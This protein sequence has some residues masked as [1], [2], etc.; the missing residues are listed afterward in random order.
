MVKKG[1][2]MCCSRRNSS[3]LN[4]YIKPYYILHVV[5]VSNYIPQL[6]GTG[7]LQQ[8]WDYIKDRVTFSSPS[9]PSAK[10][11]SQPQTL[12]GVLKNL[13]GT[14][15][16]ISTLKEFRTS[17]Q[18]I[19]EDLDVAQNLAV[20]SRNMSAMLNQSAESLE[21]MY[22]SVQKMPY[23]IDEALKARSNFRQKLKNLDPKEKIFIK[24]RALLCLVYYQALYANNYADGRADFDN[25]LTSLKVLLAKEK[26]SKKSVENQKDH[27]EKALNSFEKAVFALYDYGKRSIS[28]EEE[29][30]IKNKRELLK[31]IIDVIKAFKDAIGELRSINIKIKLSD[32]DL[33][34][35][36]DDYKK[37]FNEF[38]DSFALTTKPQPA[39]KAVVEKR[40]EIAP[41]QVA[42][43][44]AAQQERQERKREPEAKQEKAKKEEE[45]KVVLPITQPGVVAK[46]LV[47]ANTTFETFNDWY[48]AAKLLPTYFGMPGDNFDAQGPSKYPY[49]ILSYQTFFNIVD[50]YKKI[51]K[52]QLI[53]GSWI[54]QKFDFNRFFAEWNFRPFV[55]KRTLAAGSQ[56]ILL[57][58]LHGDF[59]SFV[60]YIEY[61]RE[62]RLID[63]NLK[64]KDNTYLVFLGDYVDRGFYGAEVLALMMSIYIKNPEQVISLRG[65][66]EDQ[67]M[68][69]GSF[70]KE[71]EDKFGTQEQ[72]K[73]LAN[74]IYG[75]YDGLPVVLLLGSKE[76]NTSKYWYVECAHGSFE[77]GHSLKEVLAEEAKTIPEKVYAGIVGINRRVIIEKLKN[78]SKNNQSLLASLKQLGEGSYEKY[79]LEDRPFEYK[80]NHY[81]ENTQP[82]SILFGYLWGDY[83]FPDEKKD[84]SFRTGRGMQWG[85]DITRKKFELD[86]TNDTKIV[87]MFRAHQH[88]GTTIPTLIR[89][90]GLY[91]HFSDN[92]WSRSSSDKVR[93]D[94]GF[95]VTFNVAPNSKYGMIPGNINMTMGILTLGE[96]FK[97]TNLQPVE[98]QVVYSFINSFEAAVSA[99]KKAFNR[100]LAALKMLEKEDNFTQ[101]DIDPLRFSLDIVRDLFKASKDFK[102]QDSVDNITKKLDR[103]YN[104]LDALADY[105]KTRKSA[106]EEISVRIDIDDKDINKAFGFYKKSLNNLVKKITSQQSP[107]LEIPKKKEAQVKKLVEVEKAEVAAVQA[108]KEEPVKLTAVMVQEEP[109]VQPASAKKL[110]VRALIAQARAKQSTPI[111]Q[112][113]EKKTIAEGKQVPTVLAPRYKAEPEV[114]KIERAKIIEG[115]KKP[116]TVEDWKNLSAKLPTFQALYEEYKTNKVS[117]YFSFSLGTGINIE[118]YPSTMVSE[119]VF[120]DILANYK[121]I[122]KK[123][124]DKGPWLVGKTLTSASFKDANFR[125]FAEK[126]ALSNGAQVILLGDLHGDIHSLVTCIDHLRAKKLIDNDLALAD[127]VYLVFLG[128][129]VDRGFYGVEVLAL[130]MSLYSKNPERVISLRG[131]HEDELINKEYGFEQELIGKFGRDASDIIKLSLYPIYDLLPTVLLLGSQDGASK[132]WYVECAHGSFELGHSVKPLLE[133]KVSKLPE[134]MYASITEIDRRGAIDSLKKLSNKQLQ[135]EFAQLGKSKHEDYPIDKIE[136]KYQEDVF[137]EET[138]PTSIKFGYMWGDY[139]FPG[140]TNSFSYSKNRGMQWGQEITKLKFN[141]DSTTTSRIVGMFRAHQHSHNTIPTLIQHGGLY[142]HFTKMQ[143]TIESLVPLTLEPEFVITFNVAP[144][145][146]YG[147]GEYGPKKEKLTYMTMGILSIGKDFKSTKLQPV[148]LDVKK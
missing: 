130:M 35:L 117:Q 7:Y 1:V 66:H 27:L 72:G 91:Q 103:F 12:E 57:G 90:G 112:K 111:Q 20:R 32:K 98:F 58:D 144:D 25:A 61:L 75:A 52:D 122:R 55:E 77:L 146:K 132:Y 42:E 105:L 29:E 6:L 121:E 84:F 60:D 26:I 21:I 53:K 76:A 88:S 73:K 14:I 113:M 108:K 135:D 120:S 107:K 38:I 81:D 87:G 13:S 70:T 85:G 39:K 124:L 5:L 119:D 28:D 71:L 106:P 83:N 48:N 62:M 4:H 74:R 67:S 3:L 147:T 11:P 118:K 114:I 95:V 79:P 33:N 30:W 127:N 92:Q 123:Q 141:A 133:N 36:F 148:M 68:N 69:S 31:G 116:I 51:R 139:N 9:Q 43:R 129:Y 140:V 89:Y 131:N 49:T 24:L 137:N 143:W 94:D 2:V 99:G 59:N 100:A 134:K 22:E 128:D 41:A 44:R 78:N 97:E 136:F 54:Q 104:K 15:K 19:K 56:V 16:K 17:Y 23:E 93:L 18:A 45:K 10:T 63:N 64:L 101:D 109:S 37:T 102:R 145:T 110:D 80:T 46:L 138:A 82:G 115:A 40:A 34:D 126:Q 47:D 50:T 86:S 125:P 142:Q 96:S 8:T 65:N